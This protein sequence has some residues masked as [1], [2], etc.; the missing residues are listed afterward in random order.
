MNNLKKLSLLL[1]AKYN[2]KIAQSD[3]VGW[4]DNKV[5]AE[6]ANWIREYCRRM[7][8]AAQALL[9]QTSNQKSPFYG[10]NSLSSINTANIHSWISS[11]SFFSNRDNIL[12]EA[13][14]LFNQLNTLAT[15]REVN[16]KQ[17]VLKFKYKNYGSILDISKALYNAVVEFCRNTKGPQQ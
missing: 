11:E 14:S 12:K 4:R 5:A 16:Q 2:K 9:P 17:S 13:T 15:E 8:E 6:K 10:D 3:D 7:N 1:E